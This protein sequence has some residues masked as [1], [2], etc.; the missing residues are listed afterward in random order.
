MSAA[1]VHDMPEAEYRA[2]PG[3]SGTGVV[4]LLKSPALYRE[5]VD[6]P[7]PPTP[8]MALGTAFHALVLEGIEPTVSPF[9][10]FRTKEAREWRDANPQALT[11]ED[12]ERVLAMRDAVLAHPD[13]AHILEADGGTG[14]CHLDSRGLAHEGPH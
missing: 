9:D 5:S 10:S 8:A 1:I 6:N 13:A 7:T 14:H 4:K 2:L 11:V 3:L 12:A